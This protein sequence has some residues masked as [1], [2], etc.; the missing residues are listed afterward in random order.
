[1]LFGHEDGSHAALADLLQQLVRT[2]ATAWTFGRRLVHRGLELHRRL[3][4][5]VAGVLGRVQQRGD[6]LPQGVVAGAHLFQKG[7]TLGDRQLHG[8]MKQGF[9]GHGEAPNGCASRRYHH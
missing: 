7:G 3:A 6:P 1:M 5:E 9:F 4:E 8:Q 2:D